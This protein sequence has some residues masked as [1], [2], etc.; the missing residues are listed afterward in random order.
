[1]P[2]TL[3]ETRIGTDSVDFTARYTVDGYPG[4]AFWLKE[5]DRTEQYEGDVVVCDDEECDHQL[6]EMCWT[7][8]DTSLVYDLER[9]IAVM[10]GDD[11]AHTVDVADL[12]KINEDD[13][14]GDCG[15]VGC[16]A[17]G[18]NA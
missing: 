18:R 14:C 8:G 7:V 2:D 17:D 13:F 4:V 11:R 5:Y 15:Q 6:S 9:V 16:V 1:M 10:V 12:T 3:D